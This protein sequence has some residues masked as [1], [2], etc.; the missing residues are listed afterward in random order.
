M[1]AHRVYKWLAKHVPRAVD[2]SGDS[3]PFVQFRR[4]RVVVGHLPRI[5]PPAK[6]PRLDKQR[7]PAASAVE[8]LQQSIDSGAL[9]FP[10]PA[11]AEFFEE[12]LEE[13]GR[14][15]RGPQRKPK[16]VGYPSLQW[17]ARELWEQI[18]TADPQLLR[19]VAAARDLNCDDRTVKSYAEN[20]EQSV[21]AK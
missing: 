1:L 19:E 7:R 10:N 21:G 18:G 9:L 3:T 15:L 8:R 12:L 17:L 2:T 16:S 4:L 6:P 11:R 14:I 13:A 5:G 20:A